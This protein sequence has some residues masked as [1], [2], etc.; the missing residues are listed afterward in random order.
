MKGK[1]KNKLLVAV[2]TMTFAIAGIPFPGCESMMLDPQAFFA[3]NTCN[4]FNCDTLFFLQ[5]DHADSEM[6][7]DMGGVIDDHDDGV[8]DDHG[9]THM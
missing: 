7:M 8:V 6:D 3:E 2:S 1:F 9:D 4:I 5:G